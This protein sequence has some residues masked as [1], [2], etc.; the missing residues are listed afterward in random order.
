MGLRLIGYRPL[1]QETEGIALSLI[2]VVNTISR[3]YGG[4][5]E[6]KGCRH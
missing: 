3:N 6:T 1:P 5:E 4:R 2:I